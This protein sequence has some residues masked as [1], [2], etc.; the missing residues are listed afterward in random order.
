MNKNMLIN[1]GYGNYLSRDKILGLLQTGSSPIRRLI[2]D[3]REQGKI[4]DATTGKKTRS[5]IVTDNGTV[6][7]SS[8]LPETL[9]E[10]FKE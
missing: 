2:K 5:I 1:I 3:A 4:L 8:I 6:V 7:L 10:K 9:A